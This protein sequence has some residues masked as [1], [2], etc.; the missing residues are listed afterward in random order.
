MLFPPCQAGFYVPLSDMIAARA[1]TG[2]LDRT[3]AMTTTRSDIKKCLEEAGFGGDKDVYTSG[4]LRLSC[5]KEKV[6]VSRRV[7]STWL[8]T[9]SLTYEDIKLDRF[10]RF[11][12]L[13]NA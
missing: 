11:V 4:G 3:R 5:A 13:A 6:H 8:E 12:R 9:W 1:N 2:S 7:G 10:R